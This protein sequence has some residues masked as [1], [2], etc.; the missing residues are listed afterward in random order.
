[1]EKKFALDGNDGQENTCT[2]IF[3]SEQTR[4]GRERVSQT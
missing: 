1:M 2:N 4:R 3:H